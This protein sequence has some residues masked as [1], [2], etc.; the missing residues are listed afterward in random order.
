MKCV[1]DHC[2]SSATFV[3]RRQQSCGGTDGLAVCCF[4]LRRQQPGYV[5]INTIGEYIRRGRESEGSTAVTAR[6]RPWTAATENNGSVKAVSPR[7]CAATS[8]PSNCCFNCR[9][10]QSDKDNV[11]C[12]AALLRNSP[13]R[14]KSNFRSPAPRP[15]S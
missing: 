15:C 3:S 5:T 8:A 6:K 10:L 2:S 14:K 9:A 12:T 4:P 11:R 13:K 1:C 7:H